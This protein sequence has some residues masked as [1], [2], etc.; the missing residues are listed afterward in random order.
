MTKTPEA[1]PRLTLFSRYEDGSR[2]V[3]V[4]GD[5]ETSRRYEMG[6]KSYT[7]SKNLL[8]AITG[9]PDG[10]HWTLDRYFHQGK[11]AKKQ[12]ARPGALFA[13]F[14]TGSRIVVDDVLTP[15]LAVVMKGVSGI[16]LP[17]S[18]L[19]VG[20]R[21]VQIARHWPEFSIMNLPPSPG[22]DL[23]NRSDEVAK[24]LF[25]GF[26]KQIYA[27]GYDPDDVLQEVYKGLLA[28][29]QGKCPWDSRKSSFGHYIHMVAS[30]ILK[31]YHRKL[32][33]RKQFEQSGLR[34]YR[35]DGT[36][37][38]VDAAEARR[39]AKTMFV[40]GEVQMREAE[41][42]LSVYLQGLPKGHTADAK[43]AVRVLPYV[44]QGYPRRDIAAHLDV[45]LAAVS[46]AMTFLRR[47]AKGW[48]N[49]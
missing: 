39:P 43:L 11:H 27:A 34:G 47:S 8:A 28:R 23:V 15:S 37:G 45:S 24:L 22:V 25:A 49:S 17:Q 1:R 2:P 16:A 33:R 32:N 18:R 38:L 14:G 21:T 44:R 13:M 3:L 5:S 30:C 31:N 42:D 36:F 6:G 19:G 46:R 40:E 26:G 29:N 10:R 4:Y 41:G 20:R 9:H 35:E 48:A 7:T 12:Y